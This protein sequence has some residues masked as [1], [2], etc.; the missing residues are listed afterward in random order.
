[1]VKAIVAVG[2]AIISKDQVFCDSSSL[3]V[4]SSNFIVAT[5]THVF[6]SK[7]GEHFSSVMVHANIG[8]FN[9][10]CTTSIQIIYD[11]LSVFGIHDSGRCGTSTNAI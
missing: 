10:E 8:R 1:M 6:C 5:I 4:Q 7:H 2:S 3:S 9:I 11:V